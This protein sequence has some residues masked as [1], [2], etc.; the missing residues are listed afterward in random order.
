MSHQAQLISKVTPQAWALDAYRQL[1]LNSDPN[2]GMVTCSCLVL[3]GF[4]AGFL[5]LAWWSLKLE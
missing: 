1:L 5:A 4:G 3:T 2:L